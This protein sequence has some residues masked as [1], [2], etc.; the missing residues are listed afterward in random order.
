MVCGHRTRVILCLN[1]FEPVIKIEYNTLQTQ[2]AQCVSRRR[3][4]KIVPFAN[5]F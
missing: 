4:F 5:K 3:S 2:F 1:D